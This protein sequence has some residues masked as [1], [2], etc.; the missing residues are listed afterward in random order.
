MRVIII[1]GLIVALFVGTI[2]TVINQFE[3]IVALE[4]LNWWK[5]I[6]SYIVPF[7]VSVFSAMAV[8]PSQ[9]E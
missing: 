8:R 1:R 2:L 4:A 6:L 5:T 9:N 7:C 3:R